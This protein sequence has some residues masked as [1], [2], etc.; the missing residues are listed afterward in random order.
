MKTE[1]G[2]PSTARKTALAAALA[3][4]ALPT[5]AQEQ[6]ALEE[7]VVTAQKREQSLQDI[8]GSVAAFSEQMLSDSNTRQFSDLNNIASGITITGDADGFGGIIRIRGV[9]GNAFAPII[10][11]SV[12]IFLDEVPLGDIASAYN[13]MADI[14]RVEVLKGPQSTLFG[15]EVSSGAISLTTRRPS[16]EGIDAYFA[17]RNSEGGVH[18]RQLVLGDRLDDELAELES[19]DTGKPVWLAKAVDMA[20]RKV[21]SANA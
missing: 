12:G 2:I 21:R 15:K 11:P 19:A 10:R 8:P 7:V 16:T 9:G 14:V 20:C 13:N 3:A 18:G 5:L 17:W 1:T 4:A 6:L